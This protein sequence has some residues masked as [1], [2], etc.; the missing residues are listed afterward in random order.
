VEH[1]FVGLISEF[2]LQ[3]RLEEF[4]SFIINEILEVVTE[5]SQ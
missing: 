2:D 5:M 3:I 1:L 4:E